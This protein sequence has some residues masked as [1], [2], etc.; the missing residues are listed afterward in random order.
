[1]KKPIIITTI[2]ICC[3]LN[4]C[5]NEIEFG[6]TDGLPPIVDCGKYQW[7]WTP[8]VKCV[9]E[10]FPNKIPVRYENGT[11]LME[12][13]IY[14]ID[15]YKGSNQCSDPETSQIV[16]RFDFQHDWLK[17]KD[18]F[19]V[20]LPNGYLF[21]QTASGRYVA[22][23]PN[24]FQSEEDYS[25]WLSDD[26][27]PPRWIEEDKIL[28]EEAKRQAA[29]AA[30]QNRLREIEYAKK[31]KEFEEAQKRWEEEEAR[32]EAERQQEEAERKAEE[33]AELAK[34]QEEQRLEK[35]RE[36]E[37]YEAERR[38]GVPDGL[39]PISECYMPNY[40]RIA[41]F[42]PATCLWEG[43]PRE[44]P[45]VT[46]QGRIYYSSTNNLTSY[47][48]VNAERKCKITRIDRDGIPFSVAPSWPTD[49]SG[50][51]SIEVPA[52]Y[53]LAQTKAGKFIAYHQFAFST[54][55]EAQ[56]YLDTH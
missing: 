50:D 4:G 41:T 47:V 36:Q 51:F 24:A 53:T 26:T 37:A 9:W 32:K 16:G 55:K 14:A 44:I 40:S 52:G 42:K 8:I 46:Q 30:E 15:C 45:V 22:V 6:N 33:E 19:S 28:L 39:L 48:C 25:D 56:H 23:H 49:S 10:D 1:M 5:N 20:I 13:S 17:G 2:S 27:T 43:A 3:V 35:E 11:V 21:N 18:A 31:T 34:L 7:G 29:I 54:D 12:D 38:K